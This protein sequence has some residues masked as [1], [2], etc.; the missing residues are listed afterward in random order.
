MELKQLPYN[1][2]FMIEKF[3]EEKIQ[4][5]YSKPAFIRLMMNNPLA[6]SLI[7]DSIR[8]IIDSSYRAGKEEMLEEWS[9]S[10]CGC[11]TIE[12][13]ESLTKQG[14]EEMKKEVLKWISP[15]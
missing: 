1:H 5:L 15:K 2:K 7:M 11:G 13:K 9:C 3:K 10:K 12:N 4:E 8:E 14:R 6:F